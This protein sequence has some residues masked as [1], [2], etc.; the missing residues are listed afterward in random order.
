MV[1]SRAVAIEDRVAIEELYALYVRLLDEGHYEEWLH[2][3]TDDCVYIVKAREND[4]RGLPLCTIRLESL[5]MLHDRVY[6][7]QNTIFHE[8]YY[9]RHLVTNF[10]MRASDDGFHVEANYA[11]LRTKVGEFSE[12][13]ST[14]R[15]RD[16]IVRNGG[17]L[18]FAEKR[19][20]YDS[21][22]IANSLI[23]PI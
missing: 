12:V 9:Q 18:A 15:Y 13:Y 1:A 17:E 16:R 10:Q 6:G 19:A 14:G 2:L 3:F 22:L 8:P 23:Y 21:E 20:I 4:E 5:G 11:V 7:V